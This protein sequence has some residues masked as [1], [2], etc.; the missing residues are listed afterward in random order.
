MADRD[1]LISEEGLVALRAELAELEGPAR[2]DMAAR[3]Q[4]ARELGDLKENAEYHQAKDDQA[5]LETKIVVLNQR[6]RNAVVAERSSGGDSVGF[7]S[8]VQVVDADGKSKSWQMVGPAEADAAAGLL[9]I[10]SPIG[11]ALMGAANGS[12]VKVETPRG[13]RLLTIQKI[14]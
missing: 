1:E 8:T 2:Q 5:H 13:V 10:E 4:R 7:G 3:I 9:S 14:S 6:L 12:E 11:R